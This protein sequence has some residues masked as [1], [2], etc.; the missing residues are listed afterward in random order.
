MKTT[1][2]LAQINIRLGDVK[3]NL[4][5]ILPLIEEATRLGSQLILLP[6]L[7]S[8]GFDLENR[9]KI[10][11]ENQKILPQLCNAAQNSH[12]WIG[13]SW[14]EEE[15]ED[16]LNT[17][18][19]I[20]PHG[21]ISAKYS[22]IH[23]FGLMAESKWLK[24]G[25]SI[26]VANFP[27]GDAGL[28]I[29]YDLRFPELFRRFGIEGLPVTFIVAQWPARRIDHWSTLLKARAIENQMFIAAVNCV[30]Q[31]GQETFGGKSTVIS[32][33]GEVLVE[34][35]GENAC[36]LTVEI[37]LDEVQQVRQRIPVFKDRRPEIYDL[38]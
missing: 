17:F 29:C 18:L 30:G 5:L 11:Y 4:S 12:I 7:W 27:W 23:L 14:I 3:G 13:G 6:E 8:S 22:K 15:N 16:F 19:L 9:I 25:D 26:R 32:P 21:N 20:N 2:S 31:I 36:L 33:W 35:S 1:I 24:S 28:A 34:G 10:H 38:R 37:D